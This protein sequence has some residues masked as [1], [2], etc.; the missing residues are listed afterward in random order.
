MP[1]LYGNMALNLL[2]SLT[3]IL[4]HMGIVEEVDSGGLHNWVCM[5][6][7]VMLASKVR[8]DWKGKIQMWAGH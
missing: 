8:M 2:K 5:A 6:I 1:G 3:F 4:R 7:W